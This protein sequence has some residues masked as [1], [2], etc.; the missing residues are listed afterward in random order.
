MFLGELKTLL[1]DSRFFSLF[2]DGS[3]D[4]S[5][6]EKEIIMV[7]VPKDFYPR[8][9]ILKLEETPNTKALN[10][11]QAINNAFAD[12]GMPD[13]KQKLILGLHIT[14]Q[15]FRFLESAMLVYSYMP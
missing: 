1:T 9:Y 12:I 5:E 6:S 7:K 11:E 4:K 14:S 3:K 2:C 15:H 10:I 8:M 13:Y